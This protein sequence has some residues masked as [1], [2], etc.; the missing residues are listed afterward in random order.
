MSDDR[1]FERDARAWLEL[2]PTVAPKRAVEAALF[3]IGATPQRR[4]IPIARR[5]PRT[6]ST[7]RFA[8][9][10]AIG[11]VTISVGILLLQQP[12]AQVGAPNATATPS[13]SPIPA[14]LAAT[15]QSS[16]AAVKEYRWPRGW[17]AS[18]WPNA[19]SP[20]VIPQTFSINQSSLLIPYFKGVV[21]SSWSL[22]DSNTLAVRLQS[23]PTY[24]DCQSGE[25]GTYE[26]RLSSTGQ[27]LTLSL[28]G[29]A[30][31]SRSD[32]LAG[33]WTRS[34]R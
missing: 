1:M 30:C 11:L 14:S 19:P 24:W 8:M 3:A 29:D 4:G 5:L 6:R 9:A 10:A 15:L 20:Q 31:E 26:F 18:N 17:P 33:A 32:V 25:E 13:P 22:I 21:R 2:G 28:L 7:R 16:W 12:L 34:D 27:V 23:T